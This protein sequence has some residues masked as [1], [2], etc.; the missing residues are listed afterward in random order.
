MD[1]LP[2]PV[3]YDGSYGD[4]YTVGTGEPYE[5]YV[6]TRPNEA[7]GETENRWLNLG[8]LAIQGPRG[9]D[10]TVPGPQGPAGES[11]RW[12]V[13]QQAPAGSGYNDG[14]MFIIINQSSANNGNIYQFQNN[15]WLP[16]GNIRGP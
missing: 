2:N 16:Q 11:T 10:S 3:A 14:D 4:A 1:Q 9:E 13:G 6:F 12:Y 7:I 5:F 8:Q 15:E